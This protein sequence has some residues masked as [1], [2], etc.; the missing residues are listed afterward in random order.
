[1]QHQ[2]GSERWLVVHPE[3]HDS[4]DP[5]AI[6]ATHRELVRAHLAAH[7]DATVAEMSDAMDLNAWC[8]VRAL[9]VL[10]GE[11][12]PGVPVAVAPVSPVPDPVVVRRRKRH[13]GYCPAF[14]EV[15]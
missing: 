10:R 15:A 13:S 6:V 2:N 11:P 14:Q 9:A 8:V 3:L 1:M 4:T 5:A 7:P 12:E